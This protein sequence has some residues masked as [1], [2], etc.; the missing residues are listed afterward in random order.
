MGWGPI[1]AHQPTSVTVTAACTVCPGWRQKK[2]SPW[3]LGAV[4]VLRR[5]G[6]LTGLLSQVSGCD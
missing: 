5:E 6:P 3:A 2:T 4:T 1:T